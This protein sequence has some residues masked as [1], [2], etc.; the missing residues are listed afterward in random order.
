MLKTF[1]KNDES[2]DSSL[3][4]LDSFKREALLFIFTPHPPSAPSPTRGEGTIIIFLAA[5]NFSTFSKTNL[6]KMAKVQIKKASL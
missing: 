6:G 3:S 4:F 1:Q 5:R 2:L